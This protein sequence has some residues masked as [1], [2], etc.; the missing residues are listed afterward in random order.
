MMERIKTQQRQSKSFC[1]A[2]ERL[3]K[4][5][6]PGMLYRYDPSPV[7]GVFVKPFPE[8][9]LQSLKAKENVERKHVP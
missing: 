9:C 4:T 6:F 1:R 7:Y 5:L 8:G 2:H 3:M